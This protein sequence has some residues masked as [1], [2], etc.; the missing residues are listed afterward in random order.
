MIYFIDYKGQQAGIMQ[1]ADNM[2]KQI[3]N[4]ASDP[5]GILFLFLISDQ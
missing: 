2:D 1:I 5:A 4:L 3:R